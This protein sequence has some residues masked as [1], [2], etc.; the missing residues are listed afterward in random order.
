MR[1]ECARI[2]DP[3]VKANILRSNIRLHIEFLASTKHLPCVQTHVQIAPC[4]VVPL[5]RTPNIKPPGKAQPIARRIR[6]AHNAHALAWRD[7]NMR[8]QMQPSKVTPAV[9]H[10]GKLPLKI[11]AVLLDKGNR[12]TH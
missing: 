2:A 8:N 11:R 4:V 9:N 5:R 7:L 12:H 3:S 6:T 10:T 1:Q